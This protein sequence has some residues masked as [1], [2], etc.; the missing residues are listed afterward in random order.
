MGHGLPVSRS[1]HRERSLQE[2]SRKWVPQWN[3]AD[4]LKLHLIEA[5]RSSDKFDTEDLYGQVCNEVLSAE[6]VPEVLDHVH[7]MVN[8]LLSVQETAQDFV[9]IGE[10]LAQI[11]GCFFHGPGG[12]SIAGAEIFNHRYLNGHGRVALATSVGFDVMGVEPSKFCAAVGREAK[13][14]AHGSRNPRMHRRWGKTI[15]DILKTYRSFEEPAW[16]HAARLYLICRHVCERRWTLYEYYMDS[17]NRE[18][19]SSDIQDMFRDFDRALCLPKVKSGPVP[20]GLYP[21]INK[22]I[23]QHLRG[24]EVP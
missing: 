9:E 21:P 17:T 7:P 4:A 18:P 11:Q 3:F 14:A 24:I 20:N 5:V 22:L 13:A 19:G 6:G 16:R 1:V 8:G 15:M 23:E 12:N 2:R 10:A